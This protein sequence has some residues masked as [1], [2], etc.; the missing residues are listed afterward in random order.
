VTATPAAPG[1]YFQALGSGPALACDRRVRVW[2]WRLAV[3]RPGI[4]PALGL[5]L[6]AAHVP[7][8]MRMRHPQARVAP[9]LAPRDST[10]RKGDF[11]EFL[12]AALYSGRMGEIVPFEKLSTKPVGGATQQG[13]DV[14]TLTP[15]P[16]SAPEAV[17]VEVKTR[18][19]ISH[20]KADLDEIA[21]SLGRVTDEYLESAWRTAVRVMEAHPDHRQSYALPAA[22]SLAKLDSPAEPGPEHARN[23][24][25]VTGK[26]T[27]TAAMVTKYWGSTP[28]VTDLHLIVAPDL[29]DMMNDVYDHAATLTYG[30]ADHEVP[31]FL[32]GL[33]L[34]P[35]VSAMVS[36]TVPK[37]T[38]ALGWRGPMLGVIELA[39]WMLAG[40]D[41]MATA[42]AAQLAARSTDPGAIGLAELLAGNTTRARHA[43]EPAH[44]LLPLVTAAGRLWAR[45][46]TLADFQ[47]QAHALRDQLSDPEEEAAVAYVASAIG[48]RY[49][50]H[51]AIVTEAARATGVHMQRAITQFQRLGR[52]AL[53]PS[54]AQAVAGGLLDRSHP[55]LAIKMPTSGGKTLLIEMAVADALDA[56]T[57]AVA[58]VVA[59]TRALVAQL[60]A[61]LRRVLP[62]A[63][64]RSSHG[65]LD[66]DTE[67]LSGPGIL[68]DPGVVVLT[69]ERL[70][71]EWRR[72]TSGEGVSVAALRLLVIDEAHL[73]DATHR[74]PRL[75]LLIV[76]ALR[77]GVRVVLLSSQ[78]PD[79]EVLA[80]WLDG[81]SIESDWGPTWLHR[82][83]Y[84]RSAGGTQ[85]ILTDEAGR[86]GT[87]LSLAPR[88]ADGRC[89][90][91]RREEA[92]ALAEQTHRD[93]LVVVF[94]DQR[95]YV[96]KLS[97][98]VRKRFGQLPLPADPALADRIEP[99][100]STYPAHWELLRAGVGV[101]HAQVPPTVRHVVEQ[102]ARK[103]LLRCVVCTPTLLE[104]V[105][106]PTKTVICAYPPETKGTPQV[107][108]LRNLA[109][110]A[111]RG[112][113]FT[114]GSLIVMVESE[115]Q[116]QKW[117]RAF[118]AELP[119]TTSAL[120]QAL[121]HLRSTADHLADA[122][123]GTPL[124]TVDAVILEAIAEGATV[125][126]ELRQDL[127]ALLTRT[128]W[129][130][131]AHPALRDFVLPRAAQRAERLRGAVPPGP[132]ASA[133]YRTGLPVRSCL[134]LRDALAGHTAELA[135]HLQDPLGDHDA[136]LLALATC[137][138]PAAPELRA[139]ADLDAAVLR[140][141]LQQWMDGTPVDQ[142]AAAHPDAWDTIAKDLDSL[143]PWVLT[144]A[145]EFLLVDT[146]LTSMRDVAHARLGISRIRYGVPVL[147]CCDLVRRGADRVRVAELVAEYRDLQSAEQTEISRVAF[148]TEHLT[149]LA[150]AAA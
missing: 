100:K 34:Q 35:G 52:R 30:D 58:A 43:L 142:I 110:R 44:P 145:V 41:G 101:H 106:F 90:P 77:A 81:K 83:V 128:L 123:P 118:R 133:F 49:P 46:A 54:Q 138:A 16:R 40:W 73:L 104:G 57:S 115:T 68:D 136:L 27:L 38:A 78:F 108:R 25:I 79:T 31:T 139:W 50:R 3:E 102:C 137:I 20:P 140:D 28:P 116:V 9:H 89:P 129:Y 6:A 14:L 112:G 149:E 7:S 70:D 39:L 47:Q 15:V 21:I 109:G 36:S 18:P 111:G 144:A 53:W 141:V 117:M 80:A 134:A 26:A 65:G 33:G 62:V 98:A 75:E 74:G 148:V 13:T 143:L 1:T 125:D 120:H 135:G 92:A 86:T 88:G 85:G 76:R 51:P 24:V 96:D 113:L 12:T 119:P 19:T 124:A 45:T 147:D 59:P 22:I 132:W 130:Q 2:N 95:R 17:V 66:F 107:G 146:G 105:D 87:V 11:G 32:S 82:Q 97:E 5:A 63:K 69:P 94:S 103:G 10:A 37:E 91:E 55:S 23:A 8:D 71:L 93:G 4:I 122:D 99:L 131:G 67:D 150:P 61:S 64:V 127:E 126:G 84:S 48:Y 114:S 60:A 56:D 121:D 29:I 72:A 42:R